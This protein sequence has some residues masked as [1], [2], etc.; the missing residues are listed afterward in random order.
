MITPIS[1]TG[2]QQL[3]CERLPGVYSTIW[4]L[5]YK[6]NELKKKKQ[7]GEALGLST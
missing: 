1:I 5:Y 4:C 6:T 2:I 7:K 3:F